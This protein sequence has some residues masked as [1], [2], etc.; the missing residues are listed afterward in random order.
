M[1][2][3]KEL[4][5]V[6]SCLFR[7]GETGLTYVVMFHRGHFCSKGTSIGSLLGG[8]I[9]QTYGGVVLFRS[10]GLFALI[11]GVLFSLSNLFLDKVFPKDGK[12]LA[13]TSNKRN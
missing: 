2:F 11:T 8:V 1:Q 5:S 9:F 4:V 10:M 6:F 7:T 12:L 13:T 3:L